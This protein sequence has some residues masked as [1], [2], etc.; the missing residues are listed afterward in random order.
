MRI[1]RRPPSPLEES[2]SEDNLPPP[3]PPPGSPPPHVFPPRIK[4]PAVNNV[5][6]AYLATIIQAAQHQQV[7][8]TSFKAFVAIVFCLWQQLQHPAPGPYQPG[9]YRPPLGM[10]M[11]PLPQG[12]CLQNDSK[13]YD[14]Y[15]VFFS[16]HL[17]PSLISVPPHNL[18]A[19]P[20][21]G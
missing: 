9:L 8:N 14:F 13:N 3:S 2:D 7:K 17:Q 12:M 21:P 10:M 19:P 6:P 20:P 18:V 11:A 5:P 1:I 15:N 4:G 16:G